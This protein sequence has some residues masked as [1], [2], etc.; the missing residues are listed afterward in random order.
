MRKRGRSLARTTR[1]AGVAFYNRA[2]TKS[3]IKPGDVGDASIALNPELYKRRCRWRWRT[4]AWFEYESASAGGSTRDRP[5]PRLPR[6]TEIGSLYDIR[7][8]PLVRRRFDPELAERLLE[9][10][11]ELDPLPYRDSDAG[12][13]TSVFTTARRADER[14]RPGAISNSTQGASATM[15]GS[16]AELMF[17]NRLDE[18]EE[19]LRQ[20]AELTKPDKPSSTTTGSGSDRLEAGHPDAERRLGGRSWKKARNTAGNRYG[21]SL[22]GRRQ[23]SHGR[24][25]SRS[26]VSS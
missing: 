22:H 3:T 24:G 15:R 26:P 2:G 17:E 14:L 9:K 20:V 11:L 16:A 25:A 21:E 5:E 12:G 8:R 19:Q 4:A 6:R 13:H 10:A 23:S 7:R 1:T 18:A